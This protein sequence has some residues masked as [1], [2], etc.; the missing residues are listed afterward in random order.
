MRQIWGVRL[1]SYS[2][3]ELFSFLLI[4]LVVAVVGRI[5]WRKWQGSRYTPEELERQRREMLMGCGKMGDATLVDIRDNL[6]FYSYDVRGIEYTASQDV[7]GLADSLPED[8]DAAGP[9]AVKYDPRNPAN[10][11]IISEEWSGIRKSGVGR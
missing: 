1:N 10:S 2:V 4:A 11:I 5:V 7:G 8:A 9:V 3:T 6:V